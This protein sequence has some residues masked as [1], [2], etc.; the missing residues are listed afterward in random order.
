[1]SKG[2]PLTHQLNANAQPPIKISVSAQRNPKSSP[3]V[4]ERSAQPSADR[5]RRSAQAATA[6]TAHT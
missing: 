5:I 4:P 1:M 3:N 6:S 2:M